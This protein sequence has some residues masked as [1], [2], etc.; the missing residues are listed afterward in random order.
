MLIFYV[1]LGPL[2]G[3]NQGVLVS[4]LMF[5]AAFFLPHLLQGFILYSDA[6]RYSAARGT[7]WIWSAV[8]HPLTQV[9]FWGGVLALFAGF[10]T[11]TNFARRMMGND[12]RQR[13]RASSSRE[14]KVKR[15][16]R[17]IQKLPIEEY[18]SM[19]DLKACS[20]AQLKCRLK[21]KI[22]PIE[23]EELIRLISE[24]EHNNSSSTN[25]IICCEDYVTGDALR[26]LPCH[27]KYHVECID[28]WFL[29][30]TDY[31]R[32]AACPLCNAELFQ[33]Q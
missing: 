18:L 14:E 16:A 24:E 21:K 7:G 19:S 33:T 3:N 29:S 30:S 6:W 20:T 22:G 15:V 5:L 12:N 2:L 11:S 17:V 26:V 25:C 27:H 8:G 9:V 4:L 31:S 32:P 13:N 1:H 23:K 28:K 10:F